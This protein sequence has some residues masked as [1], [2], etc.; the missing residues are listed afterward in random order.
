M[1]SAEEMLQKVLVAFPACAQEIRPPK[2]EDTREVFRAVR[3]FDGELYFTALQAVQNVSDNL[4]V[5]SGAGLH[6]FPA[7]AD[8]V[9]IELRIRRQPAQACS[10]N[11]VVGQVPESRN[12]GDGRCD[13]R[14]I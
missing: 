9:S 13:V 14:G 7:E 3:V 2:E 6:G 12:L 4:L 8:G 10:D 1:L 5:T 11:I